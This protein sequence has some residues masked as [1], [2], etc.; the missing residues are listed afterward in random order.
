MKFTKVIILTGLL[1]LM[2]SSVIAGEVE[3]P[4]FSAMDANGDAGIDEAEFGKGKN[5]GVKKTFAEVD[6]DKDGKISESEYEAI[7]EPDCD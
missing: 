4:D 2:S 1:G 5:E 7:K 6:A 3:A